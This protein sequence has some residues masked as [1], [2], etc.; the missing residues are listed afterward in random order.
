MIPSWRLWFTGR[1]EPRVSPRVNDRLDPRGDDLCK[2]EASEGL[3]VAVRSV[4][5][6]KI[7]RRVDP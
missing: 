6:D 7:R 2:G 3:Q 5:L 4:D 1:G